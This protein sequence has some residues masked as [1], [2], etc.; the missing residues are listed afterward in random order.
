MLRTLTHKLV[1]RTRG[2]NELYD[3]RRDP[4][5]LSNL[6]LEP[7]AAGVRAQLEARL[8]EWQLHTADVVPHEPD[9][10]GLPPKA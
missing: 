2:V 1:R 7:A 3:L 6:Y 8:L 4:R 9:P 10:R 5:E